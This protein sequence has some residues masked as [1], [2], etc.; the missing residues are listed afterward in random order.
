MAIPR[1]DPKFR[2]KTVRFMDGFFATLDDPA[3]VQ[4]QIIKHCR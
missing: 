4:S 2:A 1:L 3:R